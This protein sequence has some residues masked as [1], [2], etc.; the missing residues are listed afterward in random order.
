MSFM[1]SLKFIQQCYVKHPLISN[2]ATVSFLYASGDISQQTIKG[3]DKYNWANTGR[4]TLLTGSLFGPFYTAWYPF[5]ERVFPGR[6][7]R[8]VLKKIACDQGIAGG[9]LLMVFYV[10]LSVLERKENVFEE[11]KQKWPKTFLTGCVF[12][13]TVQSVN[14]FYVPTYLR[15]VYVACWSFLWTNILC[16]LKST[17]ADDLKDKLH[18]PESIASL[19]GMT[20][21]KEKEQ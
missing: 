11:A 9:I 10:G 16:Y 20:V 14:F 21:N 13:P 18:V 6:S 5:L 2:M 19:G 8:A 12:W 17:P 15:T 1:R 7:A 4:I 3:V